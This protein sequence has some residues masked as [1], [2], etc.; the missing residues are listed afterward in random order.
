MERDTCF[1][2]D[3][4]D[5]FAMS[6]RAVLIVQKT[7]MG[8]LTEVMCVPMHPPSSLAETAA[9]LTLMQTSLDANDR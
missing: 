3:N 1:L 9:L 7:L 4:H 2:V 5:N 6:A 8:Q